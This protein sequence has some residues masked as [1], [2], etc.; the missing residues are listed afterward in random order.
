MALGGDEL[1][2]HNLTHN[3]PHAL[4]SPLTGPRWAPCW[5]HEPCY[6]GIFCEHF[7]AKW[8]CY[9]CGIYSEYVYGENRLYH[10]RTSQYE[11]WL[12]NP[13]PLL[14]STVDHTA[15]PG[16]K[17]LWHFF[18]MSHPSWWIGL[19]QNSKLKN[20]KHCHIEASTLTD[21]NLRRLRLKENGW[22]FAT[23]FLKCKLEY[24][25]QNFTEVCSYGSN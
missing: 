13:R 8:L 17:G 23:Y 15:S 5:S 12:M 9:E 20:F 4:P 11:N 2:L 24:F 16:K 1:T 3:T 14:K 19:D 10:D 18:R 21:F 22:H 6:L 25:E 7:G